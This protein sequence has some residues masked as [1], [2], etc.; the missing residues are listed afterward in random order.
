M[1][2]YAV[3]V[4]SGEGFELM[5]TPDLAYKSV[6]EG[7][8]FNPRGDE[9]QI[10]NIEGT[11]L[12]LIATS[13]ISVAGYFQKHIF[14]KDA[15]EKPK[16]VVAISHCFRTEA[17]AY[18]RE[19]K[20]LYRVHQFTKV[21]MF[22]F[23]KPEDSASMH[24]ELLRVEEKIMQG[25]E[26]PY[27]VVDIC[28]GDLGGPAYRKYD[29]EAWMP[30]RNDYGEVTSTSNCTD[31]QSRRLKIKYVTDE[32]KK[33]FVHTLN[34]TAIVT[35]RIPIALLENNQQKDGSIKI[36]KVLY[37]YMMGITEIRR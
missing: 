22:I 31:Y 34:G 30:F 16:K 4:A 13:E 21:E 18:G 6:L 24:E 28:T 9:T 3:A 12:S 8:G 29:I 25:L 7:T 36:P 11:E 32:G 17:G 27:R 14:E 26:L 15:L 33:E 23:C 5:I 19:S 1:V 10:Y 37:P 20:G 2:N 35:S